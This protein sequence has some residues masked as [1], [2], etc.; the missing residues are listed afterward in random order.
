MSNETIPPPVPPRIPR[1]KP[2]P[3]RNRKLWFFIGALILAII[4]LISKDSDD[5]DSK[6]SFGI[7]MGAD[8]CPEMKE[9]WSYGSGNTK[10]IRIPL[11]GMITLNG[12]KQIF[13]S[14]SGS[15]DSALKSIR[16]ATQDNDVHAI[17]MD[18]DSGGGG[19]T[20]S[21]I[22]Y[23]AL[24]DFKAKR[25][26]RKVISIFGDVS[27]SGAFYIAMA[28]DHIIAHP[29]SITGSIGV[30][31]QSLDLQGLGEKIGIKNRTIKSGKN[32]DTLNPFEEL[33][34]EQRIIIQGIVDELQNRFVS[35]VAKGRDQSEETIR[36]IADG[37]ILSATQALDLNLIDQIGYWD[38]TM[39]TTAE[40]L[41]VDNIIVYR[42]EQ[43][44]SFSSLFTG[45]IKW[46]PISS[47]YHKLSQTRLLYLWQL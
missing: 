6:T 24:I 23:N 25:K 10:V 12:E 5:S 26:N 39:D 42:Y 45:D 37:R 13:Q 33:T 40:L 2:K 35:I 17:I 8:E 41:S 15:A 44:F 47:I 28:S 29:T 20:A 34:E 9:T 30:L 11:R 19:I 32:K 36:E 3:K 27:A 1:N 4:Y 7:S 46:S 43:E 18:I 31:I 21:D 38:D 16:R 22:I 14:G